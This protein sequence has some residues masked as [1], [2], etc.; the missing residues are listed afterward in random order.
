MMLTRGTAI[1]FSLLAITNNLSAE[2]LPLGC[3]TNNYDKAHLAKH[4]GQTI[5]SIKLRI[6]NS[7]TTSDPRIKMTA[8][9]D[10]TLRGK[11]KQKWGEGADCT[12]G[13]GAWN[14]QIEC[15][16]GGFELIEDAKGLTLINTRGF[17][18]T[19]DGCGENSLMIE[20]EP[21]NRRFRLSKSELSAC[22]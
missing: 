6:E 21:G 12:S 9:Y 22:K 17:R 3:Y 20:P 7:E 5:T 1:A 4:K 10:V 15:D 2:T 19:L 13:P 8:Y 16:G 11:G 18:V 14:C